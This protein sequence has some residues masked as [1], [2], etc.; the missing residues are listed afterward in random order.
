MGMKER[1]CLPLQVNWV[2][3][4]HPQTFGSISHRG[5]SVQMQKQPWASAT[6][7]KN[8]CVSLCSPVQYSQEQIFHSTL[9]ELLLL[10][11]WITVSGWHSNWQNYAKLFW[12][13]YTFLSVAYIKC[14]SLVIIT[15][16]TN[17]FL[18]ICKWNEVTILIYYVKSHKD[19]FFC[20]R[21]SE[22]EEM[23]GRLW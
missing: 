14:Y 11:I 9:L 4:R 17:P 6:K 21:V 16:I 3:S 2:Q 23:P 19:I 5:I 20:N 15:A 8:K 22:A 12:Q 10:F 7:R 18:H 1:S 13:S